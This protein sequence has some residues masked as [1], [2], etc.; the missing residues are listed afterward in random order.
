MLAQNNFINGI[1]W[2]KDTLLGFSEECC[3]CNATERVPNSENV[4]MMCSG[5]HQ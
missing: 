4:N 5:R 2:V 1:R 3:L